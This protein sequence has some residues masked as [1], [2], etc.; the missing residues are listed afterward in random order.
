MESQ[1]DLN[2]LNEQLLG[3]FKKYRGITNAIL[4][5]L[6]GLTCLGL[7]NYFIEIHFT[8]K[9]IAQN[10]AE[11]CFQQHGIQIKGFGC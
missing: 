5:I 10:S 6:I 9:E 3:F 4:F 11:W 1:I 2:K 8:F 7:I